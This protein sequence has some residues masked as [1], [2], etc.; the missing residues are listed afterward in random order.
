MSN[1]EDHHER[2]Y[3]IKNNKL[4][5]VRPA[6]LSPGGEISI[7]LII[8]SGIEFT[9]VLP[10]MT[11]GLSLFWIPVILGVLL[12]GTVPGLMTAGIATGLECALNWSDP[13]T[14]ADY[15]S[16]LLDNL[17]EP[18]LW[19]LAVGVLGPTRQ[20]QIDELHELRE[21]ADSRQQ[22]VQVLSERCQSLRQELALLEHSV[23][24]SGAS[25]AGH[26][27]ELLDDLA[28]AP[29]D[30][31]AKT[32]RHAL[33]RL[34]GAEGV[35]ILLLADGQWVPFERSG[36]NRLPELTAL[37]PE[38]CPLLP[39]ALLSERRVLSCAYSADAQALA[40][41]AAMAAPLLDG[42]G[43]LLGAVLVRE[44]DPACLSAAGEAAL[45]VSCFML[46]AKL[47]THAGDLFRGPIGFS[48][49]RASPRADSPRYG[50]SGEPVGAEGV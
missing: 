2:P 4:F 39:A 49:L 13:V 35:E 18:I 25:N 27:V 26:S 1:I 32:F 28:S 43:D 21:R 30:R 37:F 44:V 34:L 50:S 7:I 6:N 22:Q 8:I 36:T 3:S 5:G 10:E 46:G 12:H 24:V 31:L 38:R 33:H 45:S 48:A 42:R 23:A 29:P 9:N 41:G 47:S 19:L 15:Y 14:H 16:Y 40:D 17:S 11:S 20:R